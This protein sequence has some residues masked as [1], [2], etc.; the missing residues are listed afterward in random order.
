[1]TTTLD[2][3]FLRAVA[4]LTG[5]KHGQMKA[6]QACLLLMALRQDR[7]N[8]AMMPAEIANGNRH[9]SGAATG[10]LIAQGLLEVV[11]PQLFAEWEGER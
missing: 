1:M 7:I 11:L 2:A 6:A 4:L 3:S 9:V 8:A 10:A 5:F